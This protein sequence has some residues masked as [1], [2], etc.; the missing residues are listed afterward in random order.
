MTVRPAILVHCLIPGAGSRFLHQDAV[1]CITKGNELR[2]KATRYVSPFSLFPPQ[3]NLPR[4]NQ[5]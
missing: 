1:T 4:L 2:P 3:I 5:F